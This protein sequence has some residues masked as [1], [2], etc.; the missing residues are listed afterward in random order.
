MLCYKDVACY[1]NLGC[2]S[3]FF[4]F[5][6]YIQRGSRILESKYLGK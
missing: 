2:V 4:K 6:S 3:S 5:K 1:V